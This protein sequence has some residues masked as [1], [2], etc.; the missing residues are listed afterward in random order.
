T[1]ITPGAGLLLRLQS[2]V[3]TC[4]IPSKR[5]IV[6]RRTWPKPSSSD[7]APLLQKEPLMAPDIDIIAPSVYERGGIPH[8]QFKWLRDNDP[9]HWHADTAEGW[10]GFWAVTRHEDVEHVSRHREL[11]SS[12]L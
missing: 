10:P 1:H 2:H 11:F 3:R 7:P 8:E 12:H 9:V 4:S 5:S 6:P